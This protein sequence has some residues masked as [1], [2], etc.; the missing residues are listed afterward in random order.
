[1]SYMSTG[2][3][4]THWKEAQQ[5]GYVKQI[6]D[7]VELPASKHSQLLQ[8]RTNLSRTL[9]SLRDRATKSPNTA[10]AQ[11]MFSSLPL[12]PST[13]ETYSDKYKISTSE[14]FQSFSF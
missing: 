5:K 8:N 6:Q 2:V 14:L 9:Q 7:D 1:M 12:H 3:Y 4:R 13:V 11:Q 10:A